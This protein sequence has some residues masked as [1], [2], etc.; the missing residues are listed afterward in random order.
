M[1]DLFVPDFPDFEN[2]VYLNQDSLGDDIYPKASCELNC[3]SKS[4]S[5]SLLDLHV[6]HSPQ[7]LSGDIFYKRSQPKYA[8]I[9]IIRMLHVH[10][11]YFND[12]E[13]GGYQ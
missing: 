4:F 1:D 13:A 3:T 10:S 6:S 11:N 7:G 8:G 2:F 5:C 9:D 12:S